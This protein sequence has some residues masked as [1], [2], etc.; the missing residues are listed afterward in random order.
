VRQKDIPRGKGRLT[1]RERERER[2]ERDDRAPRRGVHEASTLF[3]RGG[4]IK[5]ELSDAAKFK[6][7]HK[8][9]AVRGEEARL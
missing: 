6:E 5:S 2:E 4:A 7:S 9:P 1:E 8:S 3:R